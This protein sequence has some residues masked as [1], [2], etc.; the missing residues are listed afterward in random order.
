MLRRQPGSNTVKPARISTLCSYRYT[1]S[2][3]G[4]NGPMIRF[5]NF[6]GATTGNVQIAQIGQY[7]APD[8][9]TNAINFGFLTSSSTVIGNQLWVKA[10]TQ[11]VGP[12]TI[13]EE[14]AKSINVPISYWDTTGMLEDFGA[15]TCAR[16]LETINGVPTRACAMDVDHY[17]ANRPR[18]GGL[19]ND[20]SIKDVSDFICEVALSQEGYPIR[21]RIGIA[22]TDTQDKEFRVSFQMDLLDL[23]SK[24]IKI[25]P[26]R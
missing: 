17:K 6:T 11:I 21:L 2:I 23:N 12:S 14:R 18:F 25:E 22:G 1:I 5:S 9:A 7:I 26:P 10:N 4:Q 16:N 13:D 20:A 3:I 19:L 15:F 8:R 24:D